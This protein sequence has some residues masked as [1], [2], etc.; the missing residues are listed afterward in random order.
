MPAIIS[1]ADGTVVLPVVPGTDVTALDVT[2]TVTAGSSVSVTGPA[3][4]TDPVTVTVTA[5]DG[6]TRDWTVRAVQMRSPVLPGLYADPN[7]AVFDGVYHIY[8]TSDGYPGWGGQEFYVWSST[9]LVEWTRSTEPILTLDGADGDVPWAVGN[10]WAPTIIERDGKFYFYFSG[11]NAA[12][13]RKTIG[14]AVADSPTGP[15]AAQP[16]AM[17]TN[18]EDVRS[19]QAI[20]PAAFRDPETASTTCSG[21]TAT[22][23]SPSWRTTWSPS[24]P[25]APAPWRDCRT[26]GRARSSSTATGRTT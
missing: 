21:A 7:I 19:G 1:S 15:F 22:R 14:V 24:S 8:A 12:L 9:D 4:Y 26:T 16:E 17:I 6:T 23:C 10:A 25:A 5:A 3:D 11:H 2:Y 20:D 18:G 13:N